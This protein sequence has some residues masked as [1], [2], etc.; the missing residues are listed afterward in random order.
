M[1]FPGNNA[2]N[3]VDGV[4]LDTS[5]GYRLVFPPERTPEHVTFDGR[6]G[7][8]GGDIA[9]EGFPVGRGGG[10]GARAYRTVV[11][12]SNAVYNIQP[13]APG[14]GGDGV[15]SSQNGAYATVEGNDT[16]ILAVEGGKS[17]ANGGAGGGPLCRGDGIKAGGDGDAG[18]VISTVPQRGG[19]GGGGASSGFAGSNSANGTGGFVWGSGGSGAISS[20]LT[21]GAVSTLATRGTAGNDPTGG[22]FA[23]GGGGGGLWRAGDPQF[24]D[25]APSKGKYGGLAAIYVTFEAPWAPARLRNDGPFPGLGLS[26]TRVGG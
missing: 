9:S 4:D 21:G 20:V 17:G 12:V 25:T 1:Y 15:L 3:G 18:V 26:D 23:G 2:Y 5:R 11:P 22:P 8:G 7:G 16:D 10:G 14:R 19:G 24:G 6:A 13:G